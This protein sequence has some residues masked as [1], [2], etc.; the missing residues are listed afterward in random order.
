MIFSIISFCYFITGSGCNCDGSGDHSTHHHDPIPGASGRMEA[1]HAIAIL[2]IF[3]RIHESAIIAAKNTL[4]IAYGHT[5]HGSQL[6]DGITALGPFMTASGST[7][8]LYAWNDGPLSGAL[9]I[10]DYFTGNDLGNPDRTTW[11]SLTRTYLNNP[12]NSDVNVVM[13]SWCGQVSSSTEED[14]NT[15]LTLM[16]DLEFDYPDVTF[17]YMTGH[18]D[19]SGVDGNLNQRN[20]QIRQYCETNDKVLYD[21]AD[22][23]SYDPDNNYYLDRGATD[24]CEYDT[25]ADGNPYGDGNWATGWQ[26]THALNTDWYSCSCAHSVAVNCNKKAYAAWWLWARI[27]GWDGTLE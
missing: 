13:W 14:I 10:D 2:D 6:I 21:F 18:L 11:A 12:A 1:T 20:N 7:P 9:D 23:E 19:G 27:A 15:Y 4:H 8:G 17:I 3:E 5:S 25:N 24:G 16:N 22:I 26:N